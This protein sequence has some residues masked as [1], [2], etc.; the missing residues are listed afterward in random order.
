MER[1]TRSKLSQAEGRGFKGCR[2]VGRG[3]VRVDAEKKTDYYNAV[4]SLLAI[5][6]CF[7]GQFMKT[8]LDLECNPENS[9][10]IDLLQ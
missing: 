7:V 8:G 6:G 5:T 4:R 10:L 9:T 1:R 2:G 3:S